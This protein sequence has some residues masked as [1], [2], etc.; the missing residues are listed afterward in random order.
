MYESMRV[1]FGTEFSDWF[2]VFFNGETQSG[3]LSPLLFNL[4]IDV[5]RRIKENSY[6]LHSR[7]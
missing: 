7:K 3:I 5:I 4:Y 1:R 6:W 2:D